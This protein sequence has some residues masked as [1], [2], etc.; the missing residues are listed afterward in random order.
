[1]ELNPVL[2]RFAQRAPLPVMARAVLERCLNAQDLDAWF[3]GV[4]QAQYTRSLLFSSVYELMTQVVLRQSG[5]V[6]AAWLEAEGAV[7]VS[8]A[9]VYNK[10]NGLELGTSAAL[11]AYA[12]QRAAELIGELPDG[13]KA[14]LLAGLTVKVLD[15]N[16]LNGRQHRLKVTRG[17][18]AA[19]LPGKALV[20]F[21]AAL[22][23]ITA[24]VPCEDG[25]TQERALLER[26][27]A[28]VK[29]GEVWVADRNFCTEAFLG[30]LVERGAY[31]LVREHGQI[32]VEPLEAMRLIRPASAD[33]PAIREQW[34]QLKDQPDGSAGLK[35]RRIKIEL[36][37]PTRHG[38]T[39]VY[40][41]SSVPVEVAD[42]PALAALYRQ[43]WSIERAFLHLTVQL[44]C[45]ID[46]LSYPPAALFGLACAMV[47]FNVLAVL[48]AALR[49][50]HGAEVEHTLSSH[51][52]TTHL[53]AMAES[54]EVIVDDPDWVVF[55]H[56][57][58][59]QMGAWLLQQARLVSLKRYAKAAPRKKPPKPP[60]K[61]VHDPR[62]PHVAL[63]RLLAQGKV[64]TP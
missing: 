41:L 53:R 18:T 10:L 54:L 2:K 36:A 27:L 17:S 11:V 1:M 33:E 31:P 26:V 4:A 58:L 6:R 7:G 23:A 61:R 25:Y 30:A 42:A 20:V 50:A 64:R 34:V 55:R 62:K 52:M 13:A 12:A 59:A 14:P 51:A 32:R 21:D 57:S 37:E 8:L 24:L 29:Q 9:S 44:R 40:L 38:E 47:A 19:P 39:E 3:E 60:V 56:A 35:L 48:K 43:R 46:T 22:E 45:E 15:G 16:C 63:S 28:Y 49:A 5:S